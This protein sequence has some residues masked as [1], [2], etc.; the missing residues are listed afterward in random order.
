MVN[1]KIVALK[2]H[3]SALGEAI[4]SSE[5]DDEKDTRA[6]ENFNKLSSRQK[7]TIGINMIDSIKDNLEVLIIENILDDSVERSQ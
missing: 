2:N 1:R 6:G 4:G 7:E 3:A 5:A